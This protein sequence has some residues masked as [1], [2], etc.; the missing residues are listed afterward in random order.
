M[1]QYSYKRNSFLDDAIHVKPRS[2]GSGSG[3]G[4]PPKKRGLPV[5]VTIVIDVLLAALLL[6]VFYVTS[7]MIKREVQP[8]ALPTPSTIAATSASTPAATDSASSTVSTDTAETPSATIDPNDWRAKFAGK[9]TDGEPVI[10]ENS[11]VSA[12]ISVTIDIQTIDSVRYYVADIY[13]AD[14]Q[15]FRTAFAG[16]NPDVMGDRALA[17]EIARQHEA[18]IAIAGDH[19]VDNQDTGVVIRNGN[20]YASNKPSSDQFAMFYDGTMKAYSPEDFKYDE[21]IAAG[22]YQV[23]SF[24]P[25][26]LQN[27]QPMTKFNM[28]DQIGGVNPRAVVGYFEPGH[29][30]FVV[31]GGRQEG[32]AEGC[33][34]EQLSRFMYDLN[35]TEAYNLDGGRSAEIIFMGQMLNEQASGRRSAY[36][37]LYVGE[38]ED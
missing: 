17:D 26:L 32:Y 28:P 20:S 15:Y 19:C 25:M 1:N 37:I 30:C 27:G 3:P 2:A 38:K 35:C 21:V 36:D 24:G 4:K 34:L 14:L 9:F 22:V 31:V 18:I 33:T 10:T 8:T 6:L 13:V 12:N 23:W 11:Y 16:K 29:Y 5:A 7:F